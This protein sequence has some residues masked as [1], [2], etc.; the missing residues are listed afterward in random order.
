MRHTVTTFPLITN[1]S[2]QELSN[3]APLGDNTVLHLTRKAGTN[4]DGIDS[5]SINIR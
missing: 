5:Q 2:F 4:T 3:P 1:D